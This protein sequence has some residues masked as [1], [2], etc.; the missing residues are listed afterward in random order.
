MPSNIDIP[1]G[2]TALTYDELERRYFKLDGALKGLAIT[3][4]VRPAWME[5][6]GPMKRPL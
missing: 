1:A 2:A 6:I 3:Q 4:M 5:R